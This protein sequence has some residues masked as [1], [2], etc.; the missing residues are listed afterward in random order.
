LNKVV[1]LGSIPFLLILVIYSTL[2]PIAASNSLSILPPDS[3]PYGLTYD[4]HAQNFWKWLLSIPANE[5]PMDDTKGDK[6]TVGQTNTNSSIFYLGPGEGKMERT[7]TVP[8]GKGLLIPVM[9]VE[10]SDKELPGASVEVLTNA[11]KKDQDSVN[12]L[13]LKVDN[14]EYTYNDLLKYRIQP[15]EPFEVIF[16]DNGIFGVADGGPSQVV[17]D[18]FYILTEPLTAGNHTVHFRSSLNCPDPGCVE[19]AFAMDVKYNIIA[20]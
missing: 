14:E 3:E 11:A 4:E 13:Y 2:T 15:T 10:Q 9:E 18:G 20:K 1:C 7:C 8:A 17:A 5:S 12:S 6:C 16:P 19:P